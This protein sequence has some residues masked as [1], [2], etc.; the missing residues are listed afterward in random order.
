M[1]RKLLGLKTQA[2][3]HTHRGETENFWFLHMQASL[4]PVINLFISSLSR[5]CEIHQ[6]PNEAITTNCCFSNCP[7]MKS[8][9]IPLRHCLNLLL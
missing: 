2:Q 6:L 4:L 5:G 8:P 3:W 7:Y 1:E 9:L